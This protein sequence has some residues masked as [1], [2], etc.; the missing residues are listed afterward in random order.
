MH[1][2][3]RYYEPIKPGVTGTYYS[4]TEKGRDNTAIT[5]K[6]ARAMFIKSDYDFRSKLTY[7]AEKQQFGISKEDKIPQGYEIRF[8]DGKNSWSAHSDWK[9]DTYFVTKGRGIVQKNFE[10][11]EEALKWVQDFAKQ[12]NGGKKRLVPPQA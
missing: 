2:G 6:L 8:N 10:T 5:D 3:Q 12:R 1:G 11:R 4:T 9:P 7:K